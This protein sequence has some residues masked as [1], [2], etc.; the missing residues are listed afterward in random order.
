M[1]TG[2]NKF[3]KDQK[4]V[5][6]I[7]CLL[8][9]TQENF[10]GPDLFESSNSIRFESFGEESR[11]KIDKILIDGIEL[12]AN[13]RNIALL[14]ISKNFFDDLTQDFPGDLVS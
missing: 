13:I 1:T 2:I 9:F 4:L 7:A 6:A 14:I 3:D 5:V 12:N 11:W 10:T 8:A